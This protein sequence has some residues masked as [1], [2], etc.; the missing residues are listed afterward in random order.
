VNHYL[1]NYL[2]KD[3]IYIPRGAARIRPAPLAPR[4]DDN[5]ADAPRH[6]SGPKDRRRLVARNFELA[7]EAVCALGGTPE[8][9]A[10]DD[11][12][13]H[14]AEEKAI[15][16]FVAFLCARLLETSKEDR[17][18]L[19]IQRAWRGRILPTVNAGFHLRRFEAAVGIVQRSVRSWLVRLR[20][21]DGRR[22]FIVRMQAMRR[23]LVQRRRYLRMR[24]A[25]RT[26]QA[27][28]RAWRE[29]RRYREVLGA[30]RRL[31]A[32]RRG[33]IQRR[34]Y[35]RVKKAALK[36]QATRRASVQRR[37]Y[38][39][40]R[41]AAT[42][43]Q[44]GARTWRARKEY[45]R[46]L[47]TTSRLQ[48]TR[49]GA[50]QRR[51]FLHVKKA[52]LK[53][54]ATRRG[55]VE[56]RR[57][58]RARKA[59]TTIQAGTRA[60]RAQKEYRRKRQATRRLQA[61]RRGAIQRRH[62]LR[63]KK[64]VLKLQAGAR[65]WHV[66]RDH[67]RALLAATRLQALRRG[68]VQ[69][70]NFLHV[71]RAVVRIQSFARMRRAQLRYKRITWAAK[72]MQAAWHGRVQRHIF[73]NTKRAA[74]AIQSCCRMWRAR[75][76]YQRLLKAVV[77]IQAGFRSFSW[78]KR[79][80][81]TRAAI[82][83]IQRCARLW[84]ISKAQQR[85]N[86]AICIQR[87]FRGWRARKALECQH[88]AAVCVQR[89]VRGHLAR[90]DLP[91]VIARAEERKAQAAA[92]RRIQA[93]WR[94]ILVRKWTKPILEAARQRRR[95]QWASGVIL[96]AVH[97]RRAIRRAARLAAARRTLSRWAPA[98]L[99]RC[100]LLRARRAATTIQ[101]AWRRSLR[102][103][104]D[105]A[106]AIQAGV[107][108]WLAVK[109]HKSDVASII[110]LQALWRGRMARMRA[111]AKFGRVR[112]RLRERAAEARLRPERRIG[113]RCRAALEQLCRSRTVEA[114]AAAVSTIAICTQ[115]SVGCCQMVVEGGGVG[116]LVQFI[117]RCHKNK[118][119]MT[120]LQHSLDS[121]S[122]ICSRASLVANVFTKDAL[123]T[124]T[125][126]LQTFRE[127][128]DVFLSIVSLLRLL[129][130]DRGRAAMVMGEMRQLVKQW[131]AVAGVLARTIA[132][133]RKA[134]G[135]V[136]DD[137]Y[138]D[139]T[140]KGLTH[141]MFAMTA[142]LRALND[143]LEM[144]PDTT[145]TAVEPTRPPL[146]TPRK[147]LPAPNKI[148]HKVEKWCPKNTMARIALSELQVTAAARREN[149]SSPTPKRL[150][151]YHPPAR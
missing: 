129:C 142:Q 89:F 33:A 75:K 78:R 11:F 20:E 68:G 36:V 51:N 150:K 92:A 91:A 4:P 21:N 114:A 14:G 15:V 32:A 57:Y 124:L 143:L 145:N 96:K 108:R 115:Y 62:Y 125:D 44:A 71:K 136:E 131:E 134:M 77:C 151:R 56:R 1:P 138:S 8:A 100:R 94:G 93:H 84:M 26:I 123:A 42:T 132:T 88:R 110:K 65:G 50:I 5:G 55:S 69:R 12:A 101:R 43:I 37:R 81:K 3:D 27:R 52:T 25:A 61:N 60:W 86:A 80:I 66:R 147:N 107:R 70:R 79:Y 117:A 6:P 120:A 102:R 40:V 97:R 128:Q 24:A 103:R 16:L 30:T 90:M 127:H 141:R 9:P 95:E 72:H 137:K 29:R 53:V 23:G 148:L 111:G 140:V 139:N 45:H 118:H 49:R 130:Y 2:L 59:A 82:V 47:H 19:V 121:L 105:A 22:A 39:R 146:L 31:Q 35:L 10:A 34:S 109:K 7:S 48:A 73:A 133:E 63:V 113:A 67:K 104:H 106:V 149:A 38:L 85:D 46:I 122:N 18:A 17:A 126:R 41:Q 83:R 58:L 76:H 119:H 74:I 98:F 116:A 13:H 99:D 54:Q 64:S 28:A 135:R 87:I 144:V 112:R